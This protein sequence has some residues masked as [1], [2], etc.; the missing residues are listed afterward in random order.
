[1]RCPV[2]PAFPD[3]CDDPDPELQYPLSLPPS[4][5]SSGESPDPEEPGWGATGDSGPVN[6]RKALATDGGVLSP[7]G[8]SLR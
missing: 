4:F 2:Q 1:M 6:C 5:Q 3:F 7:V 8:A